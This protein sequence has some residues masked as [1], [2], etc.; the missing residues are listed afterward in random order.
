MDLLRKEILRA[1]LSVLLNY[2]FMADVSIKGI[3]V[4]C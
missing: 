3:K 4:Y 2:T 1:K